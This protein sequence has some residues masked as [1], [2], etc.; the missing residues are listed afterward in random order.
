MINQ[1]FR[2][3]FYIL[4]TGVFFYSCINKSSEENEDEFED[5][6]E[7]ED[8][9]EDEDEEKEQ[10]VLKV[11]SFNTGHFNMGNLGGYQGKN[12]TGTL[13]LWQEWISQQK[14]DILFLQE[15]NVFFDKD[16][17]YLAQKELLD[18]YYTNIVWGDLNEWIHNGICTNLPIQGK[19]V[20]RFN[21]AYYAVV[22]FT[23]FFGKQVALVSVHL[24]WNVN[25]HELDLTQFIE[26]LGEFDTFIAGGD[27]NTT[28]EGQLRFK[29]AGFNIANGGDYGFICTSPGNTSRADLDSKCCLDNIITSPNI[30]I[31]HP[32]SSTTHV[33]DQDHLPILAEVVIKKPS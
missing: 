12:V 5:E 24:N 7:N 20:K 29:K 13:S 4:F 30:T 18:P 21:G 11:G 26:F 10:I 31:M 6:V 8:E 25:F 3:S 2:I 23:D 14:C 27:I 28:K 15:W 9:D 33:N 19:Q 22:T 17:V 1:F 32:Y 16:S